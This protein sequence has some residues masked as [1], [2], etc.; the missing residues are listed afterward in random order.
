[1]SDS[2]RLERMEGKIDKVLSEVSSLSAKVEAMNSHEE[3]LRRV[4]RWQSKMIGA[5]IVVGACI[6]FAAEKLI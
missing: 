2:I 1:M 5:G 3:R 6:G 4:E